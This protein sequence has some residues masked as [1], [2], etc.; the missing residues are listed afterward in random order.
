MA[1]TNKENSPDTVIRKNVINFFII[2]SGIIYLELYF[3]PPFLF[4]WIYKIIPRS[5]YELI[6]MPPTHIFFFFTLITCFLFRSK[7]ISLRD[8]ISKKYVIAHILILSF[9]Y[10]YLFR[11]IASYPFKPMDDSNLI[12]KIIKL[13]NPRMENFSGRFR[14][15]CF[16]LAVSAHFTISAS[17]IKI[18]RKALRWGLSM[19]LAFFLAELA[20]VF[21]FLTEI[22]VV[23]V[24]KAQY[25]LLKLASID[26]F[27]YQV[28]GHTPVVGTPL[29]KVTVVHYCS[30]LNGIAL[31][32]AAFTVTIILSG[33]RVNNLKALLVYAGG[34]MFMYAVNILRILIIILI[35]HFFNSGI[36]VDI[37]HKYGGMIL[38]IIAIITIQK[39]THDWLMNKDTKI[40]AKT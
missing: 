27:F 24:A 20:E 13:L 18:N 1:K 19:I 32:W 34:T 15:I 38:Y 26:A 31:F 29:F 9:F 39:L 4:P 8:K 40:I 6:V 17:M 11:I 23:S 30:G 35:G 5:V 7:E 22:L 28:P 21:Q 16:F 37:F 10:W 2:A 12:F 3:L 33:S 14:L 25:F 36:G